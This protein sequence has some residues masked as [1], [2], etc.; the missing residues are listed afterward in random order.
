MYSLWARCPLAITPAMS[1]TMPYKHASSLQLSPFFAAFLG[2]MACGVSAADGELPDS[3]LSD[4][5]GRPDAS[6]GQVDA[7]AV[8]DG[9]SPEGGGPIDGGSPEGSGPIDGGGA[10]DAT[11]GLLT[12]GPCLSG[13]PG[14]TAY[15][16]RFTGTVGSS[17]QVVYE[18]NGLPDTSR[19]HTGVY[20][21]QIGFSSSFVDPFLG[22]GG[23]QLNASSFID[24]ELSTLGVSSIQSATL[25]IFGRSYNTTT[26][27]SFNWQTF[28]G[29]GS[30]PTNFVANSAPYEWYSA[31]MSTEIDPN[32]DGI[33][34]RVK[35]GPSSGALVVNRIELCLEA[36]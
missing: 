3:G 2:L 25:S 29:T 31:D 23:V 20:G 32:D 22:V 35:A 16:V 30:T 15:R 26:S 36:N 10:T 5:T 17:A 33:L 34:L 4:P 19:D 13:A 8:D 9:G 14:A 27:G 1:A 12:G 21:Y 7:A 18:G 24:I 11:S 6:A 28:S